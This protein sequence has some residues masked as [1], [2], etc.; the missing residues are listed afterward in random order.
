MIA[1]RRTS[2]ALLCPLGAVLA[3][4]PAQLVPEWTRQ[5]LPRVRAQLEDKDAATVAWGAEAAAR[6][7]LREAQDALQGALE[8]WQDQDDRNAAHVRRAL[9]DALLR[10]EA[11]V[12]VA[13]LLPLWNETAAFLLIARLHERN[14][15]ALLDAFANRLQPSSMRWLAA[16]NLLAAAPPPGFAAA[17]ARQT[18]FVLFVDVVDQ[19][20]QSPDV[21]P[22]AQRAAEPQLADEGDAAAHVC[23]LDTTPKGFP[24]RTSHEL[25]TEGTPGALLVAPGTRPVFEQRGRAGLFE[26]EA[27]LSRQQRGV[28]LA[29]WLRQLAPD[30]EIET[31]RVVA[32]QFA[33]AANFSADVASA[34][35]TYQQNLAPVVERIVAA[36][37]AGDA[38]RIEPAIRVVVQ[39]L[40]SAPTTPL[41]P[42]AG[43]AK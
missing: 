39:D 36:D 35:T 12:P 9:L 33:A 37:R 3:Q 26:C 43:T 13:R 31:A 19:G 17:V 22:A 14:G 18:E 34:V 38:A 4:D 8:R 32:V 41:P 2:L 30:V 7:G 5:L 42:V 27:T 40:R 24:P 29:S 15:A 23:T 16:G 10:L 21:R 20:Q 11:Q 28:V 6:F 25:T 1:H